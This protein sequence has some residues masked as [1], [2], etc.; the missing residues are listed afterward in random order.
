MSL[1][2]DS[3]WMLEVQEARVAG[4][5]LFIFLYKNDIKREKAMVLV[6]SIGLS[7][8]LRTTLIHVEPRVKRG[9]SKVNQGGERKDVE[10][11][12]SKEIKTE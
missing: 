6:F 2:Y 5:A 12:G 1:L 11:K 10:S 4:A 8:Y 7:M 9:K 3:L